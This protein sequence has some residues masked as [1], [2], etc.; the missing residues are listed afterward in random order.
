VKITDRIDPALQELT[1][2]LSRH[3]FRNSREFLS[4]LDFKE[5]S[6]PT[7]HPPHDLKFLAEKRVNGVLNSYNTLV[8]GIIMF[9]LASVATDSN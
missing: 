8:A 1:G 5:E 3:P 2:I 6:H 7:S 4:D 9:A